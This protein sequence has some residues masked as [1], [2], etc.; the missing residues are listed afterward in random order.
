MNEGEVRFYVPSGRYYKL[1]GFYINPVTGE[2]VCLEY[3]SCVH[4]GCLC[5]DREFMDPYN[6]QSM[7]QRYAQTL[8]K[9][10][11]L[12]EAGIKVVTKWD[13]KFR[14]QLKNDPELVAFVETLDLEERLEPRDAFF[15]GRTNAVKMY[16]K[17]EEGEKIKYVDFTSLYPS[18]QI[19]SIPCGPSDRHHVR[20]CRYPGLLRYCQSKGA[21]SE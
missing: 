10:R 13:H 4:H 20:I 21:A 18:Q 2:N 11:F 8:E 6:K 16:R 14:R 1:D 19:R 9:V 12:E 5:Q 3:N 15:G 7:A 17:A